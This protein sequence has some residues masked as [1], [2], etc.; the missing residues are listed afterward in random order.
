[1]DSR[2]TGVDGDAAMVSAE[3]ADGGALS[4]VAGALRGVYGGVPLCEVIPSE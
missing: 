2:L 1:M 3:S 4:R